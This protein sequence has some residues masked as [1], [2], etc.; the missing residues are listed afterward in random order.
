MLIVYDNPYYF[1]SYLT[2]ILCG[3]CRWDGHHTP[4]AWNT[5]HFKILHTFMGYW[6]V[7]RSWSL[8]SHACPTVVWIAPSHPPAPTAPIRGSQGAS[9]TTYQSVY[10][11]LEQFWEEWESNLLSDIH[12]SVLAAFSSECA[13]DYMEWYQRVSHIHVQNPL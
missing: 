12:R 8:T 2:Y 1:N 7:W 11:C 9:A 3:L 6:G 13:P 10:T 4:I 5:M